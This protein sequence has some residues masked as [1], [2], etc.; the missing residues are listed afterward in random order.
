MPSVSKKLVTKP[1][2]SS[3][4]EGIPGARPRPVSHTQIQPTVTMPRAMKN[5]SRGL[6]I[7]S[8]DS[9]RSP[10]PDAGARAGA[11]FQPQPLGK[12]ANR[13]SL[14]VEHFEHGVKFGD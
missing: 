1:T 6:S 9:M 7:R 3:H 11:E 8:N 5:Q 13:R 14:I 10:S 12:A 2:K 4:S